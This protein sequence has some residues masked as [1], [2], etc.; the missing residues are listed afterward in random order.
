MTTATKKLS[1]QQAEVLQVIAGGNDKLRGVFHQSRQP[2]KTAE[3]LGKLGLVRCEKDTAG[4]Y[5]YSMHYVMTDAG[6]AAVLE[7]AEVCDTPG[8]GGRCVLRIGHE[9]PHDPTGV[10]GEVSDIDAA[11]NEWESA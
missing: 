8:C 4:P 6:N 9:G 5:S 2:H 3:S 10:F 7:M 1:P 11:K